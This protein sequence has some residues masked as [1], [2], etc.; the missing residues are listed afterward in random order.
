[1]AKVTP[2]TVTYTV[3]LMI[4]VGMLSI[5]TVG[6][7]TNPQIAN[8]LNATFQSVSAGFLNL[9]YNPTYNSTFV[10]PGG[11]KASNNLQQFNG[12]AFM[13]GQMFQ[14]ASYAFQGLPMINTILA[15][16]VQY[17]ILPGV[18]I[19]ALITLFLAGAGFL[20]IYFFITSWT[21]VEA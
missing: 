19:F 18:N 21:K 17:S 15:G 13:F 12:L 3:L 2:V 6:Y 7:Y 16:L 4:A 9:I 1:M 11:L 20:L 10:N 14:V 8:S 5:P